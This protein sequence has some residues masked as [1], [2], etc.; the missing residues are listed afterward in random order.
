VRHLAGSF[1][2]KTVA[3][4]EYWYFKA[5]FPGTGQKEYYLGPETPTLRQRIDAHREGRAVEA[6]EDREEAIDILELL[7]QERRGDI[8]RAL[9]RPLPP[10]QL[11]ASAHPAQ[12]GAC[13][14]IS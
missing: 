2:R 5:S 13:P 10:H 9:R 6:A 3:R 11:P 12:N 7:E 4:H 1:A 14:W 8:D